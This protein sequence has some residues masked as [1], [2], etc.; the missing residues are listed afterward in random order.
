MSGGEKAKINQPYFFS[1]NTSRKEKGKK[2]EV[3]HREPLDRKL[4]DKGENYGWK[5]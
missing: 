2:R 3:R 1:V 5:C 4:R